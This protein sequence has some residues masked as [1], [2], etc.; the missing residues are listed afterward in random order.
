MRTKGTVG[1]GERDDGGG[2]IA[3]EE[4]RSL[5]IAIGIARNRLSLNARERCSASRAERRQRL[6][7][8]NSCFKQVGRALGKKLGFA[9]SWT[10]DYTGR[11]LMT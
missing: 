6:R 2:R 7:R 10:C 4:V 9:G 3:L 11:S 5:G 1:V 8:T